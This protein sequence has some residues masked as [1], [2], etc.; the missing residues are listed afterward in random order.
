MSPYTFI[1]FSR[2]CAV[3]IALTHARAIY[4]ALAEFKKRVV[5]NFVARAPGANSNA[6]GRDLRSILAWRMIAR[7]SRRLIIQLA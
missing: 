7:S 2:L 6:Y 4:A 5:D 1:G 3:T